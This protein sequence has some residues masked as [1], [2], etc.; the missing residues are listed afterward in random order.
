MVVSVALWRKANAPSSEG[1]VLSDLS[2]Q[3]RP[4]LLTNKDEFD[5]NRN[6]IRESCDR[7]NNRHSEKD[8]DIQLYGNRLLLA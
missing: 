8:N 5:T 6:G 3:D 4:G 2:V 7:R 1:G